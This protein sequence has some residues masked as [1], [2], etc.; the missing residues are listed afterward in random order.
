MNSTARNIGLAL[1]LTLAVGAASVAYSQPSRAR[2]I[3]SRVAAMK[4]I[5]ASMG[6]INAELKKP[7]PETAAVQKAAKTLAQTR[8]DSG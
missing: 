7:M 3:D 5:Q 1:G 8:R 4:T 2:A 6:A